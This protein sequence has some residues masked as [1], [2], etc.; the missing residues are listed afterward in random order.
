MSALGS[1]ILMTIA[2]IYII[3]KYNSERDVLEQ[4]STSFDNITL[5]DH[6]RGEDHE[7]DNTYLITS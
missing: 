4:T 7:L 6:S 1:Q 3:G 2:L 5:V